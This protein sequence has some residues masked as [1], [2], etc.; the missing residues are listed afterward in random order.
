MIE[1]FVIK[2]YQLHCNFF[3]VDECESFEVTQLNP[4]YTWGVYINETDTNGFYVRT[5]DRAS[6][7]TKNL[8]GSFL[9]SH[10]TY[11]MLE[12]QKYGN[13]VTEQTCLMRTIITVVNTNLSKS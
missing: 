9:I 11:I 7:P 6:A 8:S 13:L 12:V 4:Q 1:T 2:F 10:T 3:L 5:D